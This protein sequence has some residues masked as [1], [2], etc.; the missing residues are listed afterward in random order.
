[1]R[2]WRQ[3]VLGRPAVSVAMATYNGE[4]YLP[5]MLDSLAAQTLQPDELVVRDDASEDGT[6]GILHAF[7]RRMPFRVEVIA[8]G[9]RLGY[10]QNFVAASR[11]CSGR[12]IFFADQD[13]SWRPPKLATVAHAVR[14]R[15]A[16]AVFHDFALQSGDGTPLAPSV[17]ALLADRGFGPAAVVNGCSM[18]VTRAFV[19]TWGWPPADSHLHHDVWVAI[20]STAFGQRRYV[21]S[22]LI[23]Y[24]RHEDNASGW[25]PHPGARVFTRPETESTDVELLV[26]LLIKRRV[27]ARTRAFL[28]V[29]RERGDAV[30]PEASERLART[31]RTNRRRH[32]RVKQ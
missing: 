4:R 18:A 28:S 13:D 3:T 15:E 5:E 17:Y 27:R 26:D 12:L 8:G 32:L 16:V 19:D 1:M 23:D 14:R 10:A 25:L 6:V 21:T 31:L 29:L 30:D 24:R 22:S 11:A 9:P 7:A 20:L 2:S